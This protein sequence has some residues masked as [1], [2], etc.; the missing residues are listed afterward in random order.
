MA[1]GNGCLKLRSFLV[2]SQII[3]STILKLD[4][5]QKKYV[6]KNRSKYKVGRDASEYARTEGFVI[7]EGGWEK[8]ALNTFT[9]SLG[10]SI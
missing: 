4:V 3:T 9:C 5:K 8:T 1:T 10:H 6:F 2:I 7:C